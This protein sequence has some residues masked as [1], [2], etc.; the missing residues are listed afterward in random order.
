MLDTVQ[1]ETNQRLN[2]QPLQ[3]QPVLSQPSWFICLCFKYSSIYHMATISSS[4]IRR[5]LW[6]GHRLMAVVTFGG[7]KTMTINTLMEF[8]SSGTETRSR[9][10]FRP[11]HKRSL[12]AWLCDHSD[13]PSAPLLCLDFCPPHTTWGCWVSPHW[14]QSSA[15]CVRSPHIYF[16]LAADFQ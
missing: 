14:K 13:F 3:Q 11:I 7:K 4:R 8:S 5:R 6:I 12:S 16:L 2:Y 9:S 1:L 10:K 15:L